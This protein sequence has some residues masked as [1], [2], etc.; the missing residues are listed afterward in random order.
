MERIGEFLKAETSFHCQRVYGQNQQKEVD[1]NPHIICRDD[2]QEAQKAY[3]DL[4][5]VERVL[6]KPSSKIKRPGRS[7]SQRRMPRETEKPSLRMVDES[8]LME[9]VSVR[10]IKTDMG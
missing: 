5:Q 1:Q 6:T 9:Q 7:V 8:Q 2:L 3:M 10:K 4:T